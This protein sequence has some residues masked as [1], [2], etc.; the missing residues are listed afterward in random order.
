M[1]HD[2]ATQ[3]LDETQPSDTAGAPTP[4][5]AAAPVADRRR[6]GRMQHASLA[7]IALLR[8]PSQ[9]R[10]TDTVPGRDD[11]APARAIGVGV[12]LAIP[13]WGAIGLLAWYFLSG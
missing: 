12:L 10:T 11:L 3:P 7:L 5:I 8:T 1:V 13:L 9:L 4:P 2:Q 6:P